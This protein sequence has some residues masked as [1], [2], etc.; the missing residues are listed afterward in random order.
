MVALAA[1]LYAT[2]VGG[3][4]ARGVPAAAVFQ[5]TWVPLQAQAVC[6]ETGLPQVFSR[7]T[8]L[9]A[10]H[11]CCLGQDIEY[12][13]IHSY[14]TDSRGA[15]LSELAVLKTKAHNSSPCLHIA[16][17]HRLGRAKATQ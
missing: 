14:S 16:G 17:P 11:L 1:A 10:G 6:A 5:Q 7:V 2:F 15:L 4:F 13:A 3:A 8:S 9:K 12:G